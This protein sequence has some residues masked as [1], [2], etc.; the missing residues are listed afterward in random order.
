MKAIILAAGYAT[1]MYPLTL[2]RAKP[3]IEVGGRPIID[4]II[5]KINDVGVE[6]IIVVSNAKFYDDFR[7]WNTHVTILNDGSTSDENKLGAIGDI[8]FALKTKRID[9]DVL[10][11]AGDNLFTFDL[12]E[13]LGFA[14]GRNVIVGR[15]LPS[16]EEAKKHGNIE[17]DDNG[18]IVNF[19]EKPPEPKSTL[20]AIVVYYLKKE[21]LKLFNEYLEDDNNKDAPGYFMEWLTKKVDVYAWIDDAT[22]FDIGN[23]EKLEEAE[24]W[25]NEH[26]S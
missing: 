3:L 9:D 12:S 10:I 14:N 24:R 23:K 13:F 8:L 2:N 11:I 6:E 25:V 4:Y 16:L 21:V 19:V 15:E 26:N 18:K 7:K 17:I 5:D 22:Y 1:R 20:T